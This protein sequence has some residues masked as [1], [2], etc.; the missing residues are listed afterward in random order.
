MKPATRTHYAEVVQR[1]IER[2]AERLDEALDLERL[3]ADAAIA[4]FHFH[5]IFRG[6]VGETALELAR[7]L[8]LER[9]A[10]LLT[11]TS[12]PVTHIAFGAGYEAHEAFT[13]AFRARYDTT[14]TLFRSRKYPRIELAARCGVHFQADGT[15]PAFM[16]CDSGGEHMRVE[17]STMPPLRLAAVRH[18]GPYNQI[19]LAFEQLGRLLEPVAATLRDYGSQ[20]MAIYHDDPDTVP[21]DQLRSDAA[22]AVPEGIALPTGLTEMHVPGGR[23][24]HTLHVGPYERLGDTWARFMGEWLPASGHRV[25]ATPAYEIYLNDPRTT[26]NA[27]LRTELYIPLDGEA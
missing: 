27:E 4:P 22:V 19:P 2:I 7:R 17:I 24:A 20:M 12:E 1:T 10:S 11:G 14:P 6:M 16:P 15:V 18:L 13:R 25:A 9:A 21:V 23:Y 26:P 5:R 3:A 8:R